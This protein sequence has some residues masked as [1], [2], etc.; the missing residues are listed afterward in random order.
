[1]RHKYPAMCACVDST[2]H[3]SSV[4]T[5]LA[6]PANVVHTRDVVEQHVARR[7]AVL[8]PRG[9]HVRMIPSGR[10]MVAKNARIALSFSAV[11]RNVAGH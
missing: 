8:G 6:K 2:G 4:E 11:S 7:V 9:S 10:G 3:H 5:E 1:M